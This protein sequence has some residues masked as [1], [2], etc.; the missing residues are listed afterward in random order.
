MLKMLYQLVFAL[1]V[2]MMLY[3]LWQQHYLECGAIFFLGASLSLL[4]RRQYEI[5]LAQTQ[6]PES[7][8]E[9]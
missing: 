9:H 8:L 7:S 6:E 4:I 1:T 5:R 3:Y 2:L